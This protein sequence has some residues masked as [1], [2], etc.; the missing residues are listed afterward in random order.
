M[1]ATDGTMIREKLFPEILNTLRQWPELERSIFCEAHYYG[2]TPEAIACSFRLDVSE[3]QKILKEC[4]RRLHASLGNFL[5]KFI[6]DPAFDVI[7]SG[8]VHLAPPVSLLKKNNLR[9]LQQR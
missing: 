9:A 7:V 2:R 6:A 8:N 3:V 5:Q 4:D 1:S